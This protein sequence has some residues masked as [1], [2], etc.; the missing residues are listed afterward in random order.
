MGA[1]TNHEE[2]ENCVA[3]TI[4]VN[5]DTLTPNKME[6]PKSWISE[7]YMT[8]ADKEILNSPYEWVSDAIINAAQVLLKK[9]NS[10]IAS[11][12]SVNL[13]QTKSFT[14][15]TGEFIQTIHSGESHWHVISTIG[16]EHPNIHVFDSMFCYCPNHSKVQISNLLAT[17]R[18]IIRLQY[19]DVQMQ[20]GQADCGIFAI[21]FATALS[22]G[23]H[24]GSY[25]FDQKLMRSHLLKCFQN[26][27][28][29]M[30]PIK[31]MRRATEKIKRIEK[32]HVYCI[33]RMPLTPGATWIQCV[34]CKEWYHTDTCI[35]VD[36]IYIKQAK[37][38]WLCSFCK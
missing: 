34:A 2:Q 28:L 22:Y 31:K 19:V 35:K 27:K 3:P 37:L 29:S 9:G 6:W 17:K 30:F 36:Q 10:L 38:K 32:F 18:P 14:V 33:C 8:E 23:L 25:I 13:G 7:L 21:A 11:L 12:Q 5:I 15:Q 20:S 4:L 24:P 26:G 1:I 16:T